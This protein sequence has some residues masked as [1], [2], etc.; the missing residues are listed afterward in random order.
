[1]KRVFLV[2]SV[3]SV[4]LFAVLLPS[5]ETPP[6]PTITPGVLAEPADA[7]ATSIAYCGWARADASMR[8]VVALSASGTVQAELSVPS[9]GRTPPSVERS[10]SPFGGSPFDQ[11]LA[12]GVEG[13]VAE[14][15][16]GPASAAVVGTGVIGA[17][18]VGCPSVIPTQWILGGGSTLEGVALE[19]RLFNPFPE[20]AKIEIE[21]ISE[22]GAEPDQSLQAVSVPAQSS[23]TVTLADILGF[24][25]WLSFGI[26]QVDGRIIPV[27]VETGSTGGI[28]LQ[29]GVGVSTEWFFPF[30][31]A[32]SDTLV[33]VNLSGA[34]IGYQVAETTESGFGEE[35]DRNILD[36]RSI[37][38]VPV[39]SGTIVTADAPIGAF[40]VGRGEALIASTPGAPVAAEQWLLSGAGSLDGSTVSILNPNV[41]D[42]TAVLTTRDGSETLLV[43]GGGV[44]TVDLALSAGGAQVV[45]SGPV[46]VG[47]TSRNDEGISYSVGVPVVSDGSDG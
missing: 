32:G 46:V 2:L 33:L 19:L 28:G 29:E 34:Q 15:T 27:L 3:V 5:Q 1:M 13:V 10:V 18:A 47:W 24:R 12:A 17:V 41:G 30:G 9:A 36:V 38:T 45:G 22:N 14:F 35:L 20:D 43:P 7:G 6:I 39:Q 40:L 21:A 42:V 26:T 23:R 25:Q 37:V 44:V 4:S 31:T 8:S 16:A 11:L